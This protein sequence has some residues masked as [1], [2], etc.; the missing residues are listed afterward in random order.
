ME[1][2][3]VSDA[4]RIERVLPTIQE[5]SEKGGKVILLAHFVR[6]NGRRLEEDSLRQLL[7]AL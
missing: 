4:T 5:L 1:N 6:P 2:G 7:P 3:R